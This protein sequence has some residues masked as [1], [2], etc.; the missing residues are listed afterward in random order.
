MNIFSFLLVV[1]TAESDVNSNATGLQLINDEALLAKGQE[2][3]DFP[4]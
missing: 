2:F 1:K 3:E 4:D